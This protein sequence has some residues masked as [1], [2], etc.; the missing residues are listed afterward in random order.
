[1]KKVQFSFIVDKR[2]DRNAEMLLIV[3]MYE[4]M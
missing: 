2:P 4:E 3:A 1:M